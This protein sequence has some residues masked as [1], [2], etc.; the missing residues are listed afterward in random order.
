MHLWSKNTR[1]GGSHRHIVDVQLGGYVVY[2][3]RFRAVH[4]G[5]QELV[6][7]PVELIYYDT[8]E[9]PACELEHLTQQAKVKFLEIE[10]DIQ[11]FKAVPD[12]KNTR[13]QSEGKARIGDG[14]ASQ[15]YHQKRNDKKRV[16]Y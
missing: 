4:P 16:Y 3:N 13:K 10:S 14:F 15:T 6:N 1:E 11:L 5:E 8:E 9:Y 7:A 12:I 2:R